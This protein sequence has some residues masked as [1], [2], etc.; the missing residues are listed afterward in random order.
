MSTEFRPADKT[1][2]DD[3]KSRLDNLSGVGVSNASTDPL[4][5]ARGVNQNLVNENLSDNIIGLESEQALQS[6]EIDSNKLKVV[7]QDAE[8]TSLKAQLSKVNVNQSESTTQN[9]IA[10]IDSLPVNAANA[11]AQIEGYGLSLRQVVVNGNFA[12]NNLTNWS[13]LGATIVSEAVNI[14]S[15]IGGNSYITRGDLHTV[16]IKY[17]VIFDLILTSGILRLTNGGV[18]STY[19]TS[20]R[21][22]NIATATTTQFAFGRNNSSVENEFTIDN[23]MVIPITNTPLASYTAPQITALNL[24]YWEGNLDV[25]N[26]SVRTVGVNLFDVNQD[27]YSISSNTKIEIL[28][29]GIEVSNSVAGSYLGV[30]YQLENIIKNEDYTLSFDKNVISGAFQ[31]RI[32]GNNSGLIVETTTLDNITFN[33]TNNDS[34]NIKFYSTSASSTLGKVEYTNL[35]LNQGTTALPHKPYDS[36]LITYLETFRSVGES[37]RDKWKQVNG[38][39]L[40]EEN[41]VDDETVVKNSTGWTV[42]AASLVNTHYANINLQS[43]LDY[44]QPI[45]SSIKANAKL[46]INNIEY[47]LYDAVLLATIDIENAFAISGTSGDIIARVNKTTYPDTAGLEAYLQANDVTFTYETADPQDIEIDVVGDIPYSSSNATI[48]QVDTLED[49]G[50]Y[51]GGITIQQTNSPISALTKIGL[52]D[53][54]SGVETVID[55]ADATVAVDGLSFTH[56]GLASG[57]IV[58]FTYTVLGG[59]L[60]ASLDYTYLDSRYVLVDTVTG[61]VYKKVEVVTN[62]ILVSSLEVVA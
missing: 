19:S 45:N 47:V 42:G 61:T 38:I 52:I 1:V 28:G 10:K 12:I 55:I 62:G 9:I 35:I 29:T 40:K 24:P 37:I 57:D 46:I 5:I 23:I 30:T 11:P 32:D 54:N 36:Q 22:V 34:L 48:S 8:I 33:T 44:K 15:E 39:W 60:T 20:G 49:A 25:V 17:A 21:Y 4:V 41:V 56:T 58:F 31:I 7:E 6:N 3:N 59:K 18:A 16:G 14:V 43:V 13:I 26:P 27:I 50:V 53:F 51:D 2:V